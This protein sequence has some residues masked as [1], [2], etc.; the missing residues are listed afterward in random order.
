MLS[1][2]QN[3]FICVYILKKLFCV[4]EG[5]DL[6]HCNSCTSVKKEN[7]S[8]MKKVSLKLFSN[9]EPEYHEPFLFF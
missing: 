2:H 4:F 9:S 8:N 7:I 1:D 5:P 3:Q 6:Y